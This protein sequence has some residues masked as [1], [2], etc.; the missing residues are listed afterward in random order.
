[1]VARGGTTKLICA[2]GNL[3]KVFELT[4]LDRVFPIVGTRAEAMAVAA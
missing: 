4:G 3:M 2:P 1:M